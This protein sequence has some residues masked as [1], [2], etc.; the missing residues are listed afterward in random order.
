MDS[1]GQPVKNIIPEGF[2]ERLAVDG[3]RTAAGAMVQKIGAG[4][5]LTA[6]G[7]MELSFRSRSCSTHSK[8]RKACW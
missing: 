8:T 5:E 1:S 4:I 7:R 6:G 2:A 3:T